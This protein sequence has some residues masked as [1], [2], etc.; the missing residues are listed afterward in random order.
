M[1][2]FFFYLTVDSYKILF[3][4]WLNLLLPFITFLSVLLVFYLLIVL[5]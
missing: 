4:V 1:G 5:W 3:S 2:G